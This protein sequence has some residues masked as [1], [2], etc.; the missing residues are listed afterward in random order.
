[1][2]YMKNTIRTALSLMLVAVLLFSFSA[3]AAASPLYASPRASKV[4]ATAGDVEILYEELY[5]VAMNKV[6]EMKGEHGEAVFADPA[7]VAELESFVWE[8]LLTKETALISLGYVYGID[9]H[10]G[11]I[12]ENVQT[13]ME[14]TMEQKFKG[15][16]DAYIEYLNEMYM[17]DHY[18][19]AY[20]GI[21]H[22]LANEIV[23]AM[24]GKGELETSDEAVLSH[25]NGN[26]FVRT[27]HVF[28]KRNDP[29]YTAAEN[30]AHADEIRAAIMAEDTPEERY[31]ALRDAIGGKY[32]NDFNDLLGNGY[33]FSRGEMDEVYESAAFALADYEVSPVVET[34]EGY[35]VIMRLPKEADYIKANFQTLKEKSYFVTLNAKV[36][37]RLA[38]MSLQRTSFGEGLDLTALPTISASAGSTMITVGVIV[39]ITLAVGA[40]VAIVFVVYKK[41]RAAKK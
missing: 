14:S 35:Y 5:F 8:R 40:A 41:K 30:R 20:F 39:G 10:E 3:C 34:D 9:V 21:E 16:R 11:D 33:Y 24:L 18:A 38:T 27:S 31:A 2:I 4:V 12:A 37:E 19:R 36:D 7:R 25:I 17:T 32:N 22:Y 13:Y 15:D 6:R 26:D 28:I 1:M 23:L 29:R